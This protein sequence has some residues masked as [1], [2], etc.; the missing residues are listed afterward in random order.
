MVQIGRLPYV[1][2]IGTDKG[3]MCQYIYYP[4]PYTGSGWIFQE[5]PVLGTTIVNVFMGV[6]WSNMGDYMGFIT[7]SDSRTWLADYF[8]NPPPITTIDI[9]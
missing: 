1:I 7:I 4:T 2:T 8:L 6:S 5:T 3:G 9:D